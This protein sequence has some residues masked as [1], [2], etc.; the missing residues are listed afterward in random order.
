VAVTLEV[1]E[2]VWVAED[3]PWAESADDA[4]S[5]PAPKPE[6]EALPET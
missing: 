5:E 3:A 1:G 4:L 2:A 6:P